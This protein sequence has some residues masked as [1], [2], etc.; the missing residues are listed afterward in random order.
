M[1]K[2]FRRINLLLP[3]TFAGWQ[4]CSALPLA[5]QDAE[6]VAQREIARREAALPRGT[7]AL[8]RGKIAMESGDYVRAHEDFGIAVM[9]LPDAVV[10]G[11][12]HDEAVAGFCMSG[13]KIAERR[14]QEGKYAEAEAICRELLSDR[15]DPNCRPAALLLAKLQEPGQINKTMGP[16]FIGKVEEVRKLLIDAEGYFNSGRYDLAFKKYEQVLNIDPYNTAARRGEEKI[17]LQKTRYGEE[18][19]NETR[20]RSM[21]QVQKAWEN[22]V[23]PYGTSAAPVVDAFAKDATGTARISA[24][25]NTIIIPRIEFR[26][27]SIREAMDFLRQQAAANDPSTEGRKGV[28]IVLRLTPTGSRTE[29]APPV[30]VAPPP[31]EEGVIANP[32]AVPAPASAP[33]V[34]GHFAR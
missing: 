31:T 30:V 2:T 18:A 1:T 33:I 17:D 9:Y 15:Y 32:A 12:A 25:L 13:I 29:S 27:A 21:W 14:V 4:I 24:K 19:Y 20:S 28:D 6:S 23:K 22:P 3:L 5:A 7:E 16:K 34:S 26:D 10:S 8:A 11:K